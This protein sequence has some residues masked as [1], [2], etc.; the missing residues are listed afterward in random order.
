MDINKKKRLV[1]YTRV[2]T[3][4]QTKGYSIEYQKD[5]IERYCK[6]FDYD[7]IR[8][9]KDE[10]LSAYKDR[11]AYENMLLKVFNDETIDGVI[12]DDLTRFGRSTIDLLVQIKRLSEAGKKFISIKD[13]IDISTKNGK[14]LLTMLSAIADYERETILERM[15]AGKERAKLEGTKSGKP[16][17]RP[18]AEIDWDTVKDLRKVGLSWT[19]TAKQVGVSVPTLIKRAKEEGFYN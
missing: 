19:K 7:L 16:M 2:S 8:I 15:E 10:G 9:Y 3:T 17:H 18:K 11:P 13:T 14:L 5:S 4:K 6:V 1:G 12:V